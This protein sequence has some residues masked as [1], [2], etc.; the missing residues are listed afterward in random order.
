MPQNVEAESYIVAIGILDE[1]E[2]VIRDLIHKL[3]ALHLR[4]VINASLQ[5]ATTMAVGCNLDTVGGNS[6]IDELAKR[7]SDNVQWHDEFS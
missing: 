6:V 5:Y 1:S 4:C 2:S 7:Q 3:C